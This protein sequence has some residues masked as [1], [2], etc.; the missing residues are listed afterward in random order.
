MSTLLRL[1]LK[2][3]ETKVDFRS[4][5]ETQFHKYARKMGLKG[6]ECVMCVSCN[7]KVMRFIFQE[8]V[9]DYGGAERKVIQSR[10]YRIS[11]P[12]TWSVLLTKNYA[13]EVGIE[14]VGIKLFEE[15]FAEMQ[16]RKRR[17]RQQHQ[18]EGAK[19]IPISRGKERK[20]G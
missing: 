18:H 20:V 12:G 14:F 4:N 3:I 2:R 13:R 5:D 16:E 1:V 15:H 10:T 19:V 6:D 8:V 17:E 7:E 11:G 9:V